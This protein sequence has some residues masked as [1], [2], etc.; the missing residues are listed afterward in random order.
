M[1]AA[2]LK[3][4]LQEGKPIPV[5]VIASDGR[6]TST[7]TCTINLTTL[8]FNAKAQCRPPENFTVSKAKVQI[9]EKTMGARPVF[10][11]TITIDAR[12]L[13]QWTTLPKLEVG[14]EYVM[15]VKGPQLLGYKKEFKA[16]SGTT[17]L[18]DLNLLAGDIAPLS[19]PDN[20]I[21]ANDFSELKRE[22]TTVTDVTRPADLNL[23]NR[24][25]SIDYSCLRNNFN[26]SGASFLKAQ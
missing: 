14:K 21:N 18:E 7:Q 16:F 2:H 22:W 17:A 24:V 25:N 4:S 26:Q 6:E 12:G 9:Y 13:P 15:V 20:I 10:E 3:D 23:D 5:K 8:S 1:V 19:S 11:G